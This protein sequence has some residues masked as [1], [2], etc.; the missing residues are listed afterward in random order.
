[1]WR[2]SWIHSVPTINYVWTVSLSAVWRG[3][4]CNIEV[5]LIKQLIQCF[6]CL[7]HTTFLYVNSEDQP[8]YLMM[9][10]NLYL[11]LFLTNGKVP[12][13]VQFRFYLAWSFCEVEF[14]FLLCFLP[15]KSVMHM[16]RAEFY[17]QFEF[18][19]IIEF[20]RICK[21]VSYWFCRFFRIQFGK[22]PL[23]YC[24][25]FT[26][27]ELFSK[28]ICW[29]LQSSNALCNVQFLAW[30]LLYN[31]KWDEHL[32]MFIIGYCLF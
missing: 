28:V 12:W 15:L 32:D 2:S 10:I 27:T 17:M 1:M 20:Y 21:I 5:P 11:W 8:E 19:L 22:T 25:I 7:H 31:L 26:Q 23:F 29:A 24:E 16:S 18:F 14:N 9:K 4:H 30:S 6:R 3:N 13:K